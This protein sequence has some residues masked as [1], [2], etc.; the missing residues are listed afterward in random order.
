MVAESP[1]EGSSK[2]SAPV[3]PRLSSGRRSLTS[4]LGW[5]RALGKSVPSSG[6][7]F[8]IFNMCLHAPP[9]KSPQAG[10][11]DTDRRQCL[12]LCCLRTPNLIFFFVIVLSFLRSVIQ[13]IF[14]SRT[15]SS[16]NLILFGVSNNFF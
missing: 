11:A 6:L 5:C 13:Y 10:R 8:L 15:I 4:H 9:A 3:K 12:C 2:L 7:L 16:R 1:T 14:G